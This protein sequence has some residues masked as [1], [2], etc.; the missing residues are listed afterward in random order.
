M[1]KHRFDYFAS[2]PSGLEELLEAEILSFGVKTTQK[3]RGGVSFEAYHENALKA[4]LE[5]RLASRVLKTLYSFE[6]LNEKDLY[7]ELSQIKWKSIFESHQTFKFHVIFGD[8][9]YEREVFTNSQ[10]VALKA[11]DAVVDWFRHYEKERPSVDKDHPDFSFI[12]RI[13]PSPTDYKIT[14]LW[15]LAGFPLHQ[16]GYR[17]EH[18][19][20][21]LKENLAAGL[22]QLL[23]WNDQTEHFYDPMCG[24]GTLV[25][26]AALAKGQIPPSF[27]LLE[28]QPWSF[29]KSSWFLKD[30]YLKKNFEQF[31]ID[32]KE[33]TVKGFQYLKQ[34]KVS[35]HA[36]DIDSHAIRALKQNLEI[37]GLS[38]AVQVEQKEALSI[39]RP[40]HPSLFF[41][42]PPYG[43][44]LERGEEEKLV[45]LYHD[46]GEKWKSEYKNMRVGFFTGNI[47]LLKKISLRAERKLILY[48]GPIEARLA[49]YLLY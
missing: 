2:C 36:S 43:E 17:S 33:K 21:P 34:S 20:A 1:K 28:K 6:A 46:L 15:D 7:Q 25:I 8:L 11:K 31:L 10:F 13:D 44:R 19:I 16:R 41:Y 35:I 47:P 23:K 40:E 4:V 30:E 42:N 3:T 49:T 37:S 29:L 26:E 5:S 18:V 48:N 39:A 45:K 12:I 22:I 38:Q 27:L 24:S 14:L 32:L 9:P